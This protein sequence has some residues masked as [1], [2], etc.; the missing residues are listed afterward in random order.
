M[1]KIFTIILSVVIGLNLSVKVWGQVNISE[2]STVTENFKELDLN[3]AVKSPPKSNC[4]TEDFHKCTAG[5]HA[6]PS[7]TNISN[8]LNQYTNTPGWTGAYIF[9]AGGEIK[10]SSGSGSGY[11]VTPSIDL[12]AGDAT[13]YFD[14]ATWVNDPTILQVYHASNGTSFSLVSSDIYLEQDFN[15]YSVTISGG[16]INSKIKIQTKNSSKNRYYLDNF[17]I[18]CAD[19]NP[20]IN[21]SQSSLTN[22]EYYLGY[23]PSETQSFTVSG[24]SLS[25]SITLTAPTN[26]EISLNSESGFSNSLSINLTGGI[27]PE[28]LVYVRLKA[29]L[30]LGSYNLENITASSTGA[31]N[32]TVSCSGS[33]I[34]AP[35]TDLSLICSSNTTA[36]ISW[37]SPECNYDGVVIAFRNSTNPPHTLSLDPSDINANPVFGSGT[38]FGTTTPYSYVVYKSTGNSVVVSGLTTGQTYKV[39]AYVYKGTTWLPDAQCPTITVS[40][41]GLSNVSLAQK[42][43][44]NAESELSWVLP[45]AACFDQILVVARQGSSVAYTP[46][47]DG[48]TLTANSIFGSGDD[49]GSNQYVVYKETGTG[50]TITGL[51]NDETYYAKIFVRKGTDWSSGVELVLNPKI[52]TALG[53]GD[54]AILAVNT[55][56]GFG[57]TG[58]EI[59]I[60]SFKDIAPNTSLDFTDNGYERAT[61]GKWGDTEGTIR[62]TRIGEEITAG[63]VITFEIQGKTSDLPFVTNIYIDGL[64]DNENWTA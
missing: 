44:G 16:S 60:V 30:D 35:V 39:K 20:T 50:L 62:L 40:D 61:A 47:G 49:V 63:K 3:K 6:S 37:A 10:L 26:Y 42:V 32:K 7:G 18:E 33:V 52:T 13:L 4:L 19:P 9:Q 11:I 54:L 51:T 15:T 28:T 38:S 46:T 45:S 22:F 24:T 5:T 57:D 41:L 58:D 1:K 56:S 27:V 43:D 59:S 21:V 64:L 55:Q 36:E 23:G 31:D 14:A 53:H 48:S 2:G 34:L 12:S 8:N 17:Q 25:T 29:G